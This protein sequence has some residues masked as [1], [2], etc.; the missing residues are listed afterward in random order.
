MELLNTTKLVAGY[1]TSTDKVGREWLVVV[2]KGT[3]A[4]PDRPEREPQ[5]LEDQRPLVMTDIFTGEPGSSA[6]LYENDFAPGK[7]RCDVLLN[8]SCHAPHGKPAT[9]VTVAIK[10]GSL[11]KAFKVVGLAR[12][13]QGCY[14]PRPPHLSRSL[15]CQS[16]TTTPT[17]SRPNTSRP[18]QAPLVPLNTL[19]SVFTPRLLRHNCMASRYPTPR[20]WTIL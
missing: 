3:Y 1:T 19:A 15:R 18:S 4:I 5:L 10:A 6:P 17:G 11:I 13:R 14:Q 16:A 8:G 7:P 9:A 2:A 12:T 20:N